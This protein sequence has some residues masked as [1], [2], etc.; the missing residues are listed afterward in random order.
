VLA[1]GLAFL[2]GLLTIF[3][4]CV[5]PLAPVVV[6]GAAARDPRGPFALAAGL[7]LTFGIVGGLIASAGTELGD[8]AIVRTASALVMIAL[9]ALPHEAHKRL[10]DTL[11]VGY[12]MRHDASDIAW[13]TRQLSRHVGA[14]KPVVRA[15]RSLVGEGLQVLVYTRDKPD[16]FA[17]ICGYFDYRSFSILD[18]RIHTARNGYAL[19]TFQVVTSA[20]PE[21]YRELT[22]MVENGLAVAVADD[23]PL[24]EPGRGRVSRRVRSFPITPRVTLRPDEKSQRWLLNITA[25]DRV[26]LLYAVARV[27]AQHQINLQLAKIST[28]GERVDDTFLIDG[29]QLQYNRDQIEVETELLK[30]L[31]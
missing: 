9:Y 7:A 23:A 16:L 25:S 21:H 24:R 8:N 17:R 6:A 28:L 20:M 4:P 15:R 1:I 13:H 5:L 19:D 3:N 30:V 11:D 2:A 12:F 27:L 26:G 22:S 10:W 31:A 14:D 29:A 18:A